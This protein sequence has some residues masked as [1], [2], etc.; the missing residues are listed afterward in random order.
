MD[1]YIITDFAKDK[2]RLKQ[3]KISDRIS[4]FEENVRDNV[5]RLQHIS[6]C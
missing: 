2:D 4:G 6:Q 1:G 3:N 5:I